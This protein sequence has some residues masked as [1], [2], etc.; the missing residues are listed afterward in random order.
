LSH[1][2]PKNYEN[3]FFASQRRMSYEHARHF[4]SN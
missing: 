2:K 3:I 4:N 1:P